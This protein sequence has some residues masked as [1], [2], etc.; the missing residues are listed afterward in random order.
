MAF[1][2]AA[3]KQGNVGSENAEFIHI[4]NTGGGTGGLVQTRLTEILNIQVTAKNDAVQNVAGNVTANPG[5]V[6]ITTPD[7]IDAYAVVIGK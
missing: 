7:S 5:E 6:K 3:Q 4:T 2:I 1:A